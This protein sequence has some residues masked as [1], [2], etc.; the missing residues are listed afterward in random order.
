MIKLSIEP[1]APPTR[2]L[3]S[4][5]K[6]SRTLTLNF[7][8]DTKKHWLRHPHFADIQSIFCIAPR[9]FPP[10][11]SEQIPTQ[12]KIKHWLHHHWSS[13]LYATHYRRRPQNLVRRPQMRPQITPMLRPHTFFDGYDKNIHRT[14]GSTHARSIIRTK[15]IPHIRTGFQS[16][17]PK[18]V[19]WCP[20]MLLDTAFCIHRAD[21]NLGR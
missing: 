6:K 7:N 17:T 2:G 14:I 21:Q 18:L 4:E 16:C 13:Q 12:K 19:Q 20:P 5:Q 11:S 3:S 8:I 15:K 10:P 9:P 1:S